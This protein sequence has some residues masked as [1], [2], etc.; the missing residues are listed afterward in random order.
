MAKDIMEMLDDQSLDRLTGEIMDA[1]REQPEGSRWDSE[2]GISK[3]KMQ[4]S[5][6]NTWFMF[7]VEDQSYLREF[8]AALYGREMEEDENQK[9]SEFVNRLSYNIIDDIV[10]LREQIRQSVMPD[11]DVKIFPLD[12]IV[13]DVI[14][15]VDFSSVPEDGKYLTRWRKIPGFSVD[16][17]RVMEFVAD[18]QETDHDLTVQDI[19]EREQLKGNQLFDG[20][21]SADRGTKYLYD[22]TLS[23]FVDYSPASPEEILAAIEGEKN[24]KNE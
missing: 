19:V 22:V 20:V 2:F 15:I 16:M 24:K 21:I 13:I 10:M 14:D 8:I 11:S 1:I 17:P 9:I 6:T 12:K 18:V 7:D 4:S 5:G 3:G 23:F